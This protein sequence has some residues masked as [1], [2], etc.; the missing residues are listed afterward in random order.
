[1]D[2]FW[3]QAKIKT[4]SEYHIWTMINWLEIDPYQ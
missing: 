2:T 4:S 3:T 1:M